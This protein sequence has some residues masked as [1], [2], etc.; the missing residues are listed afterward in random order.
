MK[1]SFTKLS[2]IIEE[3]VRRNNDEVAHDG[4][5]R[6]LESAA[7]YIDMA[8][9]EKKTPSNKPYSLTQDLGHYMSKN[10]SASMRNVVAR[11]RVSKATTALLRTQ[12]PP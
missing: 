8:R 12:V 3:V 2:N 10:P 1:S 5:A 4:R 11:T 6:T 7:Y 9:K